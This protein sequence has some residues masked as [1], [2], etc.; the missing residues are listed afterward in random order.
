M[1]EHA[2]DVWTPADQR[3]RV[4][5]M[6]VRD[7]DVETEAVTLQ[8]PYPTDEP[9]PQAE[10]QV[11]LEPDDAPDALDLRYLGQTVQSVGCRLTLFQQRPGH[12]SGQPR[13]VVDQR[14]STHFASSRDCL[15][16]TSAWRNTIFSVAIGPW[17]SR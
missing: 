2:L 1:I 16:S 7:A 17:A 13:L 11:V 12:H 8:Q 14:D 10:L 3:D 9:R 5:H 15:G 4:G 6:L